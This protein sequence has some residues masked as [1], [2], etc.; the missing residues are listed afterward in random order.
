MFQI[1]HVGFKK[2]YIYMLFTT[3]MMTCFWE[4]WKNLI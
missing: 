4:S 1:K 3:Y 2:Q